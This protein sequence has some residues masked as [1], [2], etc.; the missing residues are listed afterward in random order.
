M[1]VCVCVCAC[2]RTCVGDLGGK[3]RAFLTSWCDL[4]D[5]GRIL[6]GS[7]MFIRKYTSCSM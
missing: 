5:E 6:T 1:C 2:A 4:S 7:V 3:V